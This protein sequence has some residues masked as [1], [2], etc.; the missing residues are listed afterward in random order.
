MK[1]LKDHGLNYFQHMCVAFYYA[2]HLAAM[3][4]AAVIHGLIP[5][6]FKKYV[7]N[8]MKEL[9]NQEE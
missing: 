4:V 1:H 9:L 5:F 7:T 8:T 3:L 2:V 6:V